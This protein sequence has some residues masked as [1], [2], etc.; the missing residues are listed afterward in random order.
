MDQSALEPGVRRTRISAPFAPMVPMTHMAAVAIVTLVAACGGASDTLDRPGSQRN[1]AGANPER[2]G[3][4]TTPPRQS[5]STDGADQDRVAGARTG[6]RDGPQPMLRLPARIGIA[7]IAA[8]RHSVIPAREAG[9]W[10]VLA[11]RLGPRFGRFIQIT[12]LSAAA[13]GGHE[14]G[15]VAH[16]RAAA[17]QQAIAAILIYHVKSSGLTQ[18]AVVLPSSRL[19]AQAVATAVLIDARTG[20]VYGTTSAT[21]RATDYTWAS[22]RGEASALLRARMEA[23]AVAK[24]TVEVQAM[25]EEIRGKLD[26]GE[27]PLART[28]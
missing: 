16:I 5:E 22:R 20:F 12:P 19:D 6:P 3:P 18:T 26:R 14:A 9:P 17:R 8:R 1:S 7:R 13:S 11:G 2:R 4:P 27:W 23:A 21:A 25:A 15:L 28:P 10:S 24:M